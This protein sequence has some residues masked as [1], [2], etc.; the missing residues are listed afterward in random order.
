MLV[1]CKYACGSFGEILWLDEF[2][3]LLLNKMNFSY[4]NGTKT[5]EGKNVFKPGK[6]PMLTF[7]V[8]SV[9]DSESRNGNSTQIFV[10]AG[11]PCS[12]KTSLIQ[13]LRERGFE[14]VPETAEQ[15]IK[16]GIKSGISVEEQRKDPVKWQMDLLR[17][18]FSL[19]DQLADSGHS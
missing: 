8:P 5:Y 4:I 16:T 10:I 13:A 1:A 12:G 17:K 2:S 3:K 18:D 19:F 11:G 14:T 15:M 9:K 6:S 7:D